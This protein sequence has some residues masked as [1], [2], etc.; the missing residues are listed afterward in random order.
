MKA[1]GHTI[2][3]GLRT[4]DR[5]AAALIEIVAANLIPSASRSD[6]WI[7][8]VV[9]TDAKYRARHPILVTH[10][11]QGVVEATDLELEAFDFL[12]LGRAAGE[13]D[14]PDHSR[15]ARREKRLLHVNGPLERVLSNGRDLARAPLSVPLPLP[16]SRGQLD[17]AADRCQNAGLLHSGHRSCGQEASTEVSRLLQAAC[18]LHR[19][20][21]RRCALRL[22]SAMARAG[23]KT[24]SVRAMPRANLRLSDHWMRP[25]LIPAS[26][27]STRSP[28]T[29]ISRSRAR[30]TNRRK[31]L[32]RVL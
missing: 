18:S 28:A 22:P 29:S 2:V 5:V 21:Q 13:G 23:M 11:R 17:Q 8:C 12:G 26:S 32:M 19:H 4:L 16:P 14:A 25:R 10:D 3:Q 1:N 24:R 7:A 31:A 15:G 27:P 30:P 9:L 20:G 6:N